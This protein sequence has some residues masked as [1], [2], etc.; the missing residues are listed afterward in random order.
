M[1]ND[2]VCDHSLEDIGMIGR[3]IGLGNILAA[4]ISWV[5]WH[6]I[7]W[8]IVHGLCSYFYILYWALT[9]SRLI[10]PLR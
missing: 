2:D 5:T 6:S 4:I 1:K 7:P 9:Q 3:M 10:A 8:A